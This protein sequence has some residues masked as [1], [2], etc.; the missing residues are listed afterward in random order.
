MINGQIKLI[1]LNNL[2]AHLKETASFKY[3]EATDI[4]NKKGPKLDCCIMIGKKLPK[5]LYII[6]RLNIVVI[7]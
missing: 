5:M 4:I 3:H 2:V 1:I 7:Q 6:E